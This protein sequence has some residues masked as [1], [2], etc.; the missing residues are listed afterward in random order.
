MRLVRQLIFNCFALLKHVQCTNYL[1]R[2]F[3]EMLNNI[4]RAVELLRSGGV[5]A[6]PTET[7]YGLAASIEC[8][9]AIRKIF[10]IKGR[11][12]NHP[13]IVHIADKKDIYRFATDI[14]SYV[15]PLIEHF[16]PGPL[17]LILKKTDLISPLLTGGHDTV[18]IRMPAHPIALEIIK[19]AGPIAA[20]SA[21]RFGKISPTTAAHV[22]HD[23]GSSV[24]FIVD[25]GR[26]NIGIESTIVDATHPSYALIARQGLLGASDF[27]EALG[28]L[29]VKSDIKTQLA[30]SGNL[31]SHYCPNK[32]L[33][34][35]SNKEDFQKIKKESKNDLYV[36]V[37]AFSFFE[38]E[39]LY[40]FQMPANPIDY[41]YQLYFQLRIADESNACTIAVE[42]PPE[43]QGWEA[44][45]ER[46]YKA[47]NK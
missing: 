3:T 1:R 46:L 2:N 13:L 14:P 20:P 9:E 39:N 4:D 44:I 47:S 15:A 38:R 27:N 8:P 43:S 45:L 11:P 31:K 26:C 25:G 37:L 29:C 24:D 36:Y 12:V 28:Y 6:I 22:K 17:T 30:V 42:L 41:A 40:C 34:L 18:G 7:V 19:R 32:P 21:N 33:K 5:V 23:L 16:W 35:F 10:Q